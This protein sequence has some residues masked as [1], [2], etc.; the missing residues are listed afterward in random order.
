MT[1]PQLA[2]PP[3]D[4]RNFELWL[5]HA[6]G[7]IFFRDARDYAR[8]RFAKRS[9]AEQA[10]AHEAIDHA[11]YGMMMIADG[12]T[13]AIQGPAGVVHV[14]TTVHFTPAKGSP[15]AINLFD[16]DGVCMGFHGWVGGDFG[17]DPIVVEPESPALK[18]K[19]KP[20]AAKG[21]AK[22]GSTR[23]SPGKTTVR[24]AVKTK[25]KQRKAQR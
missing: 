17:E 8:Q 19:R 22:R 20:A 10:I 11:L 23:K 25:A 24:K 9:V 5:Q 14:S 6:A 16:G 15:V 18:L 13:G 7:Y 1:E 2:T 12:V 21:H 4:A 3:V